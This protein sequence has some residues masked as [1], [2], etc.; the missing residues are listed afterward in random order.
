MHAFIKCLY[1]LYVHVYVYIYVLYAYMYTL[2]QR[3]YIGL[4]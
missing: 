2:N 1:S 4:A 3:V